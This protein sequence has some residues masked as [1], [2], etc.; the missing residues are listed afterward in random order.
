MPSPDPRPD[1]ALTTAARDF[2]AEVTLL[3]AQADAVDRLWRAYRAR[4][5]PEP[6]G[7][8][9]FGREWFVLWDRA[10]LPRFADGACEELLQGV[11]V[12]GGTVLTDLTAADSKARLAG[13]PEATIHALARWNSLEWWPLSLRSTQQ[14]AAR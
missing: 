4:C 8:Y 3:T 5:Q 14:A 11:V 13:V 1:A 6:V 7:G 10:E 12:K 2:A 9:D